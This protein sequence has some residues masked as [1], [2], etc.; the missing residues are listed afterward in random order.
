MI[1]VADKVLYI[2]IHCFI[3]SFYFAVLLDDVKNLFAGSCFKGAKAAFSQVSCV[4]LRTFI[5][6]NCYILYNHRGFD[7]TFFSSASH[8]R[9]GHPHQKQPNQQLSVPPE[10]HLPIL[11]IK[12]LQHLK[13]ARSWKTQLRP[14]AVVKVWRLPLNRNLC[15]PKAKQML[16]CQQVK[17]SKVN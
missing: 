10:Q 16:P 12:G 11:V 8:V 14:K 17:R 13:Q 6:I 15:F 3:H 4:P 7:L 5:S 1:T 2:W 9:L